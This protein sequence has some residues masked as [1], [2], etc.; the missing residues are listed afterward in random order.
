MMRMAPQRKRRLMEA[1]GELGTEWTSSLEA[2]E[3]TAVALVLKLPRDH[4]LCGG[5]CDDG[6][7]EHVLAVISQS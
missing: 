4:W 6:Q 7:T 2:A 1:D 5:G 3:M